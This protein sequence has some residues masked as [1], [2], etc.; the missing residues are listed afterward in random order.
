[1]T[2]FVNLKIKSTQSFKN[3][4][5]DKIYIYIFIKISDHIDVSLKKSKLLLMLRVRGVSP[6]RT[7][8]IEL[9]ARKQ[10]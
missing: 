2:D 4:H 5:R 8:K 3:T 6:A 10:G 1:M 9:T 7:R